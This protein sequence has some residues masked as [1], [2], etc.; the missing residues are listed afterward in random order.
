MNF[1]AGR[2]LVALE[3]EAEGDA[4]GHDRAAAGGRIDR[5]LDDLLRRARAA[6]SSISMPPSV[7][8]MTVTREVAAIDQHAEIELAV[9]VAAG[10]DIDPLDL[11]A[12][13]A[14]LMGHQRH[15]RASCCRGLADFA[16]AAGD[17][18]AAGLAAAAG[19]DLG[20]HHPDRSAQRLRPLPAPR[21]A[22]RRRHRGA[23]RRRTYPSGPWPD[24]REYSS[25]LFHRC[26]Q[27]A[28][29][30]HAAVQQGR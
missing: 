9:D 4:A 14:G 23:P 5:H 17:L 11:L 22:Y 28:E 7:E 15:G 27:W 24:T 26:R 1:S 21:P 13:R 19:M 12:L 16:G 8:A 2:D 30:R 3:A 25:A 20:L 10:L 6:T 18:D 29:A